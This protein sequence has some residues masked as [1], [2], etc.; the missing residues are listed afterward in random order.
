MEKQTSAILE[1]FFWL[2]LRPYHTAV[3]GAILHHA[4]KFCPNTAIRGGVMTSYTMSRWRQRW[5]NTNSGFVSY[6]M[7]LSSEV[8]NL[9]ANQP[10]TYLN[11]QL[12]YIYFRFGKTNVRH[13]G[14]LLPVA[15][16]TISQ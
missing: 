2:L 13:I 6:A 16:S 9:P 5:L 3:I 11:P 8:Q 12:R 1:L 15:T 14:I 7:S 4:T 10:S